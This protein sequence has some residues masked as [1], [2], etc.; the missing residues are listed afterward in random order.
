MHLYETLP[1]SSAVDIARTPRELGGL[2]SADAADE[3]HPLDPH[4]AALLVGEPALGRE[5]T[6]DD[7]TASDGGQ[8]LFTWKFRDDA[9]RHPCPAGARNAPASRCGSTF[10]PTASRYRS[11]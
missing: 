7:P 4:A 10:P 3:L 9:T 11:T 5:S 6:D 1:G 2:G 8:R